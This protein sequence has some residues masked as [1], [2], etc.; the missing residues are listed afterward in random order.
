[1][2]TTLIAGLAA[3]LAGCG[4][5]DNT[6]ATQAAAKPEQPEK[7]PAHCFFKD[8]ETKGWAASR[9]KSGNI[10]VKGKAYRSDSRYQAVL[11]PPEISGTTLTI[12]PTIVQN[13]TGFGAADDWWKIDSE[14]P[15]SA[16]VDTVKITCGAQTITEIKVPGAR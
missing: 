14:I 5:A 13:G 2:R 11:G 3:L 10:S 9:G 6:S 12:W 4:Q 1:M 8:S 15:G 16:A 7:K